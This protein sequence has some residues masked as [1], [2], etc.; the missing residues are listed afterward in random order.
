M[1]VG[2]GLGNFV[3]L[4]TRGAADAVS[5]VLTVSVDPVK[6]R[7]LRGNAARE[8]APSIV[9]SASWTPLVIGDDGVPRP[10]VASAAASQQAAWEQLRGCARLAAA[11]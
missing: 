3:W 9:T 2:Y 10:P 7:A 5:G 8:G 4:N 11:P 1:H 6:A